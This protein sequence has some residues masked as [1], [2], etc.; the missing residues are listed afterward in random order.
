MDYEPFR[1][2]YTAGQPYVG[3]TLS[4]FPAPDSHGGMGNFIAWDADDGR[5][6]VVAARAVLGL[7]GRAGDRG[8]RRLLR[9]ARGLPE[10]GRRRDRRGALQVQD[11]VGHHRQRDDLRA[12]RQAVR[13]RAVG[14]RRLGRHRPRGR[15]DRA[16]NAEAWQNAAGRAAAGRALETPSATSTPPVSARSAAMRRSRDYTDARRPAD[17]LRAARLTRRRLRP[18][19]RRTGRNTLGVSPVDL[20]ARLKRDCRPRSGPLSAPATT[21]GRNR[22]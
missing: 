9:H 22:E 15:A 5:D 12:R 1:V 18:I 17:G 20:A 16:E 7:V 8:R 14:R 11:P 3:A 21:H 4:M 19:G 2:S 6:Q 13:R 10:G